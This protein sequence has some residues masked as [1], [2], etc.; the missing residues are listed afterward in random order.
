MVIFDHERKVFWKT[1]VA[2]LLNSIFRN[3]RRRN[4]QLMMAAF[5]RF[6]FVVSMMKIKA[7][8]PY[9]VGKIEKSLGMKVS[10]DFITTNLLR[11]LSL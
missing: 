6:C 2:R 7:S 1:R 8:T 3:Q 4:R 10:L 11:S 9:K 5:T